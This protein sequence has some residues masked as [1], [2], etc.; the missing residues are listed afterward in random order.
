[1]LD[2]AQGNT[3]EDL[4]LKG[5]FFA[6]SEAPPQALMAESGNKSTVLTSSSNKRHSSASLWMEFKLLQ[7]REMLDMRRS[8]A[9]V[10]I[11][12]AI[13]AVLSAIF[14]VIFLDVGQKDRAEFLV[15]RA[16]VDDFLL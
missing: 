16:L 11:N 9:S 13:T 12:V 5:H 14:G 15:S 7:A 2:V 10:V 8:P 3:I 1:M 4:E 6:E